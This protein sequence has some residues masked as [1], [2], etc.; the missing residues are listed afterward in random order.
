MPRIV[1]RATTAGIGGTPSV[2]GMSRFTERIA[3]HLGRPVE[4]ACAV[5]PTWTTPVIAVGAGAGAAFGTIV[6]GGP[7][8][9]AAGV[10]VGYGIFWLTLR[11]SGKTLA[12][13]LVLEDD[14]VELLRMSSFNKPVGTLRSIPY[15]DIAGVDTRSWFLEVRISIATGRD[16]LELA[17]GKFGVGAA[18]PVID[19]LRRRIAA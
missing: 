5:R 7:F 13:A 16:A 2:R 17:G 12:M 14:H 4:A 19:E 18:P 15:A 8:M 11:G 3:H 1:H 9:A 6:W 10:I